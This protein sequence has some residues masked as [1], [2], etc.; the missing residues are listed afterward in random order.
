MNTIQS[1]RKVVEFKDFS[2]K[3]IFQE[4]WEDYKKTNPV[5]EV[6]LKEVENML[7]CK[8]YER[9]YFIYHC[10]NCGKQITVPFGCNSRI[11]SCCG[12]RHTDKWAENLTKKMIKGLNYRH[13]TF[14]MPDILWDYFKGNYKLQKLLM[15][16]VSTT[17]KEMFSQTIELEVIPGIIEVI[18]P[19]GRDLVSKSHVHALVTDGGYNSQNKFVNLGNYISYEA[20]HKKWKDNILNALRGNG[21]P[22]QVIDLCF[23]KYPNGFAAYIKPDK[24]HYGKGLIKYI[25]RYIRHPAIAN[26]RI[27][28]YNG[29][30]VTFYYEDSDGNIH[31]KTMSVFDFI[32]AIIQHIPEKNFRMVRYY[33]VY[34]RNNIGRFTKI[35]RQSIIEDKILNKSKKKRV[36]YCPCCF[37]MMDLEFYVKKPPS[38]NMNLITNWIS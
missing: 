37:E 12:K 35:E 21:V 30:G 17:I 16:V 4:H 7:S 8:G 10:P 31:F 26:S 2:V 20:F 29:K 34:S 36:V 3:L 6:E 22:K 13:L 11:C 27:I 19:F 24:L 38:K 25:G 33:G 15:D 5:R 28:D 1:L 32:S 23:R 9:G 18:H 14:S